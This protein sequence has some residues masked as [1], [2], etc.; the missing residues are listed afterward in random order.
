MRALKYTASV[1]L[2][3][4]FYFIS[5]ISAQTL[6]QPEPVPS[7]VCNVRAYGTVGD[8]KTLDTDA[9]RKAIAA[10]AQVEGGAVIGSPGSILAPPPREGKSMA[11]PSLYTDG[12]WAQEYRRTT[13]WKPLWLN[14]GK[15]AIGR[16]PQPRC[17]GRLESI[18]GK[19]RPTVVVPR[20]EAAA[21]NAI[22]VPGLGNIHWQGRWAIIA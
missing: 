7:S 18:Q 1:L 22:D 21:E 11:S 20:P 17:V 12:L 16:M 9:I 10:C 4:G 5:G 19:D 15:G 13:L 6:V 3:A 14:S 8:G 2:L